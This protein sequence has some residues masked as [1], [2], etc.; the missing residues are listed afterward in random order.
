MKPWNHVCLNKV[1]CCVPQ[2]LS[3]CDPAYGTISGYIISNSASFSQF[4][5]HLWKWERT[6]FSPLVRTGSNPVSS[7]CLTF[8]WKLFY[9]IHLPNCPGPSS[10]APTVKLLVWGSGAHVLGG[11]LQRPLWGEAEAAPCQTPTNPL[12]SNTDPL[13]WSGGTSVPVYLRKCK[14]HA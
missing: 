3:L 11:R 9:S 7:S 8:F 12:H 1:N 10:A 13:N 5:F 14:T 6:C 4:S 2:L